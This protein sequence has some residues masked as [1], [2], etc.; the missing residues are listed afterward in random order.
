MDVSKKSKMVMNRISNNMD[1]RS[2]VGTGCA[3]SLAL[4]AS[5]VAGDGQTVCADEAKPNSDDLTGKVNP[6]QIMNLLKHIDGSGNESLKSAVFNRL[7]YECFYSNKLDQWVRQY[8]DNLDRFLAYTNE[9]HSR[10]WEKLEYDKASATL[11]VTSRKTPHC[12]CAYAQCSN[13]PK[14][15]CTHCCKSLTTTL[16]SMLLGKNVHVEVTESILLGGKQCRVTIHILE[17][18]QKNV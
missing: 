1:R 12:V 8:R 4:L 3:C 10:Y 5:L 18:E 16:F 2:F 15:L 11:K 13:P 9:G 17:K 14:S 6:Q 7:G